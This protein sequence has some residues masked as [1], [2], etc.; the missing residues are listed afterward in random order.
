M[1]QIRLI[2]GVENDLA[3]LENEVNEWIRRE[4]VKILQIFGNLSPQSTSTSDSTKALTKSNFAPSDVLLV[5][6]YETS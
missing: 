3:A 4:N 2:K 5:I 1:Q 6:L